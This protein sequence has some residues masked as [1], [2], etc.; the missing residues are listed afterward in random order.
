ML[1]RVIALL[2]CTLTCWGAELI[3]M[4]F[5]AFDPTVYIDFLMQGKGI[6]LSYLELVGR[7]CLPMGSDC[8]IALI[9]KA[10]GCGSM[11]L[12][13]LLAPLCSGPAA[14]GMP[15]NL[16]SGTGAVCDYSFS[17]SVGDAA[18]G[19]S[20][21]SCDMMAGNLPTASTTMLPVDVAYVCIAGFYGL[22]CLSCDDFCTG[23]VLLLSYLVVQYSYID[24]RKNNLNKPTAVP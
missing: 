17:L 1:L 13:N 2:C 9:L 19:Q 18:T 11:A 10:D 24:H 6:G 15:Q 8:N 20:M 22:K 12:A 23:Y 21:T 14:V 3:R 4:D 5:N 16:Y 7:P